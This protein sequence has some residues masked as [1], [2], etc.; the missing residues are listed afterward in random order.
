MIVLV[1]MDGVLAD[2]RL[3]FYNKAKNILPHLNKEEIVG[4]EHFVINDFFKDKNE[5]EMAENI[6]L[7]EGFYL[8]LPPI[9]DSVYNLKNLAK[10]H[11]VFICTSPLSK[12][13]FCVG[14]KTEWV[15]KH[16]GEEWARRLVITKDKTIIKGDVLIDDK[17]EITGVVVN[18][19]WKHVL[20]EAAYN[21]HVTNSL[22]LKKDWSNLE[23]IFKSMLN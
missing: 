4:F 20:Y 7:S 22:T 9:K 11:E 23:E 6:L 12:N 5:K 2:F 18:P 13:I 3:G 16:L 8:E 10:Q 17:P 1:D 21:S 14:E 15:K 19:D